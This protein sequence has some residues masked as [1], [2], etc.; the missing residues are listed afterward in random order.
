MASQCE[1]LYK[2]V[3]FVDD[4]CPSVRGLDPEFM[5]CSFDVYV[6]ARSKNK[7]IYVFMKHYPELIFSRIVCLYIGNVLVNKNVN[8]LSKSEIDSVV[9]P[10]VQPSLF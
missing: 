6:Q 5:P 7:A 1:N 4:S 2:I 9:D 10:F 3:G 8:Y